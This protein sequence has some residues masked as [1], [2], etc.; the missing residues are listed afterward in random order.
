[1]RKG[2]QMRNETWKSCITHKDT[3]ST[4]LIF[5][6]YLLSQSNGNCNFIKL[7]AII[8]RNIYFFLILQLWHFNNNS[9]KYTYSNPSIFAVLIFP[10]FAHPLR[11]K[12][13]ETWTV[14]S[15]SVVHPSTTRNLFHSASSSMRV[16]V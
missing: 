14:A 15:T 10:S 7:K 12:C 4:F 9:K 5:S 16:I 1:M 8:F 3:F 11:S 2:I 6:Y 13:D